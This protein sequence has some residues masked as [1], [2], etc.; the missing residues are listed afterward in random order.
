M[1]TITINI[2]GRGTVCSN[3]DS[4]KV[5]N[6]RSLMVI[7]QVFLCSL[8]LWF[9]RFVYNVSYIG[10]LKAYVFMIRLKSKLIILLTKGVVILCLTRVRWIL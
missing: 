1:P 5:G 8:R 4:S 3:G 6:M 9:G 2:A 10:S 7:L